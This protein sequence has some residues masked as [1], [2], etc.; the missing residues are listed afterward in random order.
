[1]NVRNIVRDMV[2]FSPHAAASVESVCR[3]FG[4]VVIDRV[5]SALELANSSGA[6]APWL[7]LREAA[8]GAV[9]AQPCIC[10]SPELSYASELAR[11]GPVSAGS[12][13]AQLVLALHEANIAG[14][15][16]F[17]IPFGEHLMLANWRVKCHGRTTVTAETDAVEIICDHELFRFE[18][19]NGLWNLNGQSPRFARMSAQGAISYVAGYDVDPE[20]LISE[21]VALEA[22]NFEEACADLD[23]ALS[24][25]ATAGDDA[26]SWI[27]Q[28]VRTVSL[29]ESHGG[30]RLS[31]RS[32]SSRAGNIEMAAPGDRLHIAELLVHEAA[33]QHFH[34]A[35]L[36][37]AFTTPAASDR[38]CF[39]A[40]NGRQRPVERVLLAYHAVGNI[41][42]FLNLLSHTSLRWR[43][44][45]IERLHA[46][47][48]TALHL[49]TT[50]NDN[51]SLLTESGNMILSL[52]NEQTQQVGDH[53]MLRS[54]HTADLV[55]PGVYQANV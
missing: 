37:G 6:R 5:A 35:R 27:A 44:D 13:G 33:H 41:F 48:P 38:L 14:R 46:L 39:S 23:A 21:D 3:S 22:A 31:S 43:D 50:L 17:Q 7:S 10:W 53:H 47:N 29:V 9:T 45:A 19:L 36:L 11:R 51:C 16:D 30:S 2:I 12:A 54:E 55:V 24:I 42:H 4:K 32:L 25:A 34:M 15:H 1:M 26:T 28:S 18:R 20:I 49:R 52:L 40:L 8:L